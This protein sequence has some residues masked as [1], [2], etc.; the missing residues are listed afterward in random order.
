MIEIE[1]NLNSQYTQIID[2]KC[3]S[4]LLLLSVWIKYIGYGCMV[5]DAVPAREPLPGRLVPARQSQHRFTGAWKLVPTVSGFSCC[6]SGHSYSDTLPMPP[7]NLPDANNSLLLWP[8]YIF[9]KA[10]LWWF[11]ILVIPVTNSNS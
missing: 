8:D 11:S 3:V 2:T 4:Q 6:P 1:V 10:K 7:G 9:L 5:A